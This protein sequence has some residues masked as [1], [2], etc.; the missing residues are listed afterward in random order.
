MESANKAG[1]VWRLAVNQPLIDMGFES[2][3]PHQIGT[4]MDIEKCECGSKNVIPELFCGRSYIYCKDC[5]KTTGEHILL[6]EAIGEW[7]KMSRVW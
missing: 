1:L 7:N 3:T 6:D 5:E 4:S 2:F